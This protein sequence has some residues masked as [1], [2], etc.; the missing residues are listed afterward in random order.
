MKF[1]DLEEE[2]RRHRLFWNRKIALRAGAPPRFRYQ[3]DF[4]K[5]YREQIREPVLDVGCGD[6][7]FMEFLLR[8][9][10]SEVYGIDISET[11]V[12][13]TK[14]RIFP[15]IG[16][17]VE[18]RV[19]RG[20]M[21]SLTSYFDRHFFNTIICEGTLH[22][23]SYSGAKLALRQMAEVTA[24]GALL[25]IS[26]RSLSLI[27]EKVERVEGERDT[28]RVLDEEG[29]VRCYFS[30]EGF[31]DLICGPFEIVELQERELKKKVEGVSYTMWIAV[32]RNTLHSR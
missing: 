28:Y 3:Y 29:V 13:L 19:K 15:Y 17:L 9:G 32:L 22:Q 14:S 6:G 10:L 31:L 2:H 25:Y 8:E 24:R 7:E 4:Y 18:D 12:D 21:I 1:M 26:V 20:D 5:R 23:T 16:R 11:A 30:R 27:P